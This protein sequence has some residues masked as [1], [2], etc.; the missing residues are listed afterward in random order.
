MNKCSC[1]ILNYNDAVTT[2]DLIS[3]ISGYKC[4]NKIIVVDN[5]SSDNS[6][7]E[8]SKLKNPNLIVIEADHNGGYGAGNNIGIKLAYEQ[9]NDKYVLIANPDVFFSEELVFNLI[10][11]LE[12]NEKYILASA[13]QKDRNGHCILDIAWRNPTIYEMIFMDFKPLKR[14]IFERMHYPKE[15]LMNHNSSIVDCVPG[16]MLLIDTEKFLDIGG[17]DENMFLYCEETYL[18]LKIAKTGYCSVLYS[19]GSYEHIHSVSINKSIKSELK[20]YKLIIDER[21]YLLKKYMNSKV[22]HVFLAYIIYSI[23]FLVRL[24]KNGILN[25]IGSIFYEKNKNGAD[26]GSY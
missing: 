26:G 23:I 18:G 11:L 14:R 21:I 15:Y 2:T 3:K 20:Q 8:L 22:I 7:F 17:Y 12:S 19:Q 5:C 24:I 25:K 16:A 1:V 9:L 4:F 10:R 6:F 13:I